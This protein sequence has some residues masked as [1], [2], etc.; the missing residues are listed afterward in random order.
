MSQIIMAVE[1][2]V[3]S[4]HYIIKGAWSD[5]SDGILYSNDVSPSKK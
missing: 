1:W 5:F 4:V 2:L 3:I